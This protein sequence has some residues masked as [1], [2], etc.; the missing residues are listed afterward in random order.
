MSD[1]VEPVE[2]V[3]KSEDMEMDGS[4]PQSDD[5]KPEPQKTTQPLLPENDVKKTR[6]RRK[7][8]HTKLTNQL[9]KAVA[10]HKSGIIRLRKLQVATWRD[11]L[12]R[13]FGDVKDLHRKYIDSL[14]DITDQQRQACDK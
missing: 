4:V 10:D 12:V 11:E 7:A 14:L 3:T 8:A 6:G 1:H 13:I 2:V 5:S 9:R